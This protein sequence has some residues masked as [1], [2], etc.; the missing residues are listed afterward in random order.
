MSADTYLDFNFSIALRFFQ[1][2]KTLG[3]QKQ[4]NEK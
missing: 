1:L 2:E 3:H 4:R